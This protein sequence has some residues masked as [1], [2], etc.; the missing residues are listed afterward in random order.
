VAMCRP[1]MHLEHLVQYCAVLKWSRSDHTV[2][3]W[4]RRPVLAAWYYNVWHFK[5]FSLHNPLTPV[6]FLP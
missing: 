2:L 1:D 6:D 5:S 4:S 3:K